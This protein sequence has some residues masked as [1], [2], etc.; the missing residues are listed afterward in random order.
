MLQFNRFKKTKIRC[1]GLGEVLFDVFESGKIIGG[2]PANFAYHCKENGLEA[3]VISSIGNDA[4]GFAAR[5]E[6]AAKCLPALL[7]ENTKPTGQVNITLSDAG[8]PSYSFAEDTAYDNIPLSETA[9]ELVRNLDLIGFGTLAQRNTVSRGTILTLL[10]EMHE[11]A[12]RLFDV[13]LRGDFFSPAIIHESLK[14]ANIV[15]CNEEELPILSEI[16]GLTNQS[17]QSYHAYLKTRGIDCFILT[18][19][20]KQST[21][22]LNDAVS[23]FPTPTVAVLDTVGAG[24]AFS[25]TFVSRMMLGDTLEQAHRRAVDVSAYVCT[26]DGA[27]PDLP[28]EFLER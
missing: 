21:V 6:L 18:E 5:H 14:R 19:G 28:K 10:D 25:A 26:Q 11:D 12:L 13:N 24:D 16:A 3:L 20:D 4:L 17:A 2:A 7:L 23:V 15:K 1:A 9:I 27:M 8:V 22:F